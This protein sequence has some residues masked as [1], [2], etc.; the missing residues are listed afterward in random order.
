MGEE[1]TTEKACAVQCTNSLPDYVF[2]VFIEPAIDVP[3]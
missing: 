3:V 2:H 1:P